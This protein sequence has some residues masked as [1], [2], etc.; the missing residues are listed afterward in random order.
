VLK[1]QKAQHTSQSSCGHQMYEGWIFQTLTS[2]QKLIGAEIFLSS[3]KRDKK[4]FLSLSLSLKENK[5]NSISS[6]QLPHTSIK[7]F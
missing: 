3:N 5:K 7:R 4:F 6:P 1:L 2:S